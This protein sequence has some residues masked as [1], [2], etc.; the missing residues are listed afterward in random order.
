MRILTILL[1]LLSISLSQP[2]LPLYLNQTV[3]LTSKLLLKHNAIL[4]PLCWVCLHL[5]QV[6]N[7]AFPV[8][9]WNWVTLPAGVSI[10]EAPGIQENDPSGGNEHLPGR[11]HQINQKLL[12]NTKP[13]QR[14][15]T[16]PVQTNLKLAYQVPLCIT[17]KSHP[18][19]PQV[20]TCPPSYCNTTILLQNP[21]THRNIKISGSNYFRLS[22]P[23]TFSGDLHKIP[24]TASQ[25]CVGRDIML[26]QNTKYSFPAN[27]T[28]KQVPTPANTGL[29]LHSQLRTLSLKIPNTMD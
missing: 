29:F 15:I 20:G 13:P 18:A 1:Y 24:T 22:D 14:P 7:L 5:R 28:C 27:D 26:S 25:Y 17:C 2:T 10:R 8:S 16:T 9:L 6:V 19:H 23:P 12:P 4:S 11:C 21:T 3:T